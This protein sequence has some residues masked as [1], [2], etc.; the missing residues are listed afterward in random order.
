MDSNTRRKLIME[1]LSAGDGVKVAELA[2]AC[3]HSEMTIRRDLARLEDTGYLKVH[4]GLVLLNNGSSMEVSSSIKAQRATAQKKRIDRA[5]AERVQPGS[6]LYL[7]C[8][9]TVKEFAMELGGIRNLTVYTSSLLACNV[10]CNY[11]N[12]NLFILPGHFSEISM[13]AYDSSTLT[14]LQRLR[15]DMAVLGAEAVDPRAGFMVPEDDDCSCKRVVIANSRETLVLAD[16][17]KLFM[18]SRCVY[19]L[20]GEID[21]FITDNRCTEEAKDAFS[22]E[23]VQMLTV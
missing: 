16:S 22:K 1:R 8:G 12:I 20:P 17:S 5:A 21:L 19:A 9:T 11:K 10:L 2:E 3:G 6:A 7:D 18:S 13:G 14:M 15:F 4:R 23:R